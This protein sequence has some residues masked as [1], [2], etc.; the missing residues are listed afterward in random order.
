MFGKNRQTSV[1]RVRRLHGCFYVISTTNPTGDGPSEGN[2][3][4]EPH[5]NGV[6]GIGPLF[7]LNQKNL[8]YR[9]VPAVYASVIIR[10]EQKKNVLAS[11][12]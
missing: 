7:E 3:T 10:S 5:E 8:T 12:A 11:K 2:S 6:I 9:Q 4:W 1:G